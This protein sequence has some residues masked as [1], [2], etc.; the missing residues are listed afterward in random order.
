M[1]GAPLRYEKIADS[2]KPPSS[3]LRIPF[4]TVRE[5]NVSCVR[6][7]WRGSASPEKY[8]RSCASVPM[9]AGLETLSPPGRMPA[10]LVERNGDGTT[11]RPS[12]ARGYSGGRA[13][14]AARISA[15]AGFAR[16]ASKHLCSRSGAGSVK[17]L[18]TASR[19]DARAGPSKRPAA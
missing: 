9:T 11:A 5:S 14:S 3:R 2:V 15:N 12:S 8:A 13:S 10:A 19:R 18:P 4:P 1:G 7:T 17:P 16:S 6:S